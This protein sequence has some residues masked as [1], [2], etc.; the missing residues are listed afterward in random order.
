MFCTG[1]IPNCRS[2]V[3]AWKTQRQNTTMQEI[4]RLVLVWE[5]FRKI[6]LYNVNMAL[7]YWSSMA[8]KRK[9]TKGHS[10]P[11]QREK[12]AEKKMREK[13][14]CFSFETESSLVAWEKAR[15]RSVRKR[16]RGW[17]EEIS[18]HCLLFQWD[19][20]KTKGEDGEKEG[21]KSE[22]E[23]DIDRERRSSSRSSEPKRSW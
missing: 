22:K 9:K 5:D 3:I 4:Y 10:R 18:K 23:T 15:E 11:K 14:V 1:F 6:E 12:N 19:S 8:I 17:A 13:G 2:S 16:G 21:K 20:R 7:F